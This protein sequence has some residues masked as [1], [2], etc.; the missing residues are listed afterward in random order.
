MKLSLNTKTLKNWA[1]EILIIG[2][3]EDNLQSAFE[4]LEKR[5]GNLIT[6]NLTNQKFTGG[7]GQISTFTLLQKL[8]EK[9]ISVVGLG[10]SKNLE[11]NSLRKA[12]SLAG[13][14]SAGNEGQIGILFP[15]E[16]FDKSKAV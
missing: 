1:G 11:I 9:V 2:V 8:P 12:A 10:T 14:A 16:Y 7:A 4:L 6:E 3:L 5:Y 13:R 15:W